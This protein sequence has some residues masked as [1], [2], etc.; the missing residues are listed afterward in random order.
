ML[1]G[2]RQLIAHQQGTL[3]CAAG[4]LV[5]DKAFGTGGVGKKKRAHGSLRCMSPAG[6]IHLG[7][8]GALEN[9]LDMT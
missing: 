8:N 7:L 5:V 4:G 6:F 1:K 9:R 2:W 3:K